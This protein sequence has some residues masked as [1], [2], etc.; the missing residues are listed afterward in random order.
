[1][2]PRFPWTDREACVLGQWEMKE[3]KFHDLGDH[4]A[5][6]LGLLEPQPVPGVGGKEWCPTAERPC[7]LAPPWTSHMSQEIDSTG[8][9]L[10][11][12]SPM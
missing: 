11:P 6:R 1:M 7:N 4:L 10:L 5:A 12:V 2:W 9:S 3:K 8:C